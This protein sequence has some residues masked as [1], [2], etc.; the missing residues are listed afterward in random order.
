MDKREYQ[1]RLRKARM[2]KIG[3]VM[4]RMIGWVILGLAGMGLYEIIFK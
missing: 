3:Y 4:G 1:R 2:Y